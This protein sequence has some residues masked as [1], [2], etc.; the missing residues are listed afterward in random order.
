MPVTLKDGTLLKDIHRVIICTG[1][2]ISYP[3]LS[4]LHSDFTNPE[5]ADNTVLVTDG[6]MVH[7]LHRDIFYIPD[8]SLAFVGTSYYTATF[9]LFEFQSIAVAAVF[10]A[11][12][13]LPS[14]TTMEKEYLGKLKS[15]GFGRS[16]HSLKEE[17]KEY[18]AGLVGWINED[19]QKT[20]A[21]T[22]EGHTAQWL[23]EEKL[24]M[25]KMKKMF[26][27]KAAM[28]KLGEGDKELKG[29]WKVER[30]AETLIAAA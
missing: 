13:L 10:S 22:V 11:K 16:F 20:G 26:E 1:Y 18:V 21:E 2:H 5:D 3:F 30:S 23:Q 29:P 7:N 12:A 27:N 15:K 14:K 9:T 24:I 6:T 25:I 4:H 28:E 8:P 19:A 17:Q